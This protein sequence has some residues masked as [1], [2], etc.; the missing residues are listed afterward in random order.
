MLGAKSGYQTKV[1]LKSP[2]VRGVHCMIHR[3]AIACKTLPSFLK[4]VLNSVIKI[5]NYIKSVVTSRLVRQLCKEMNADHK[6]LLYYTA[7][8]WLSEN[9]VIGR[10]FELRSEMKQV[11]E[12]EKTT[13]LKFFSDKSWLWGLA[14]LV[15]IF[16]QLNKI[17]LRLQGPNTNILQFKDVLCGLVEKIQNWNQKVNQGNFAIFENLSRFEPSG[18]SAQ[19][20]LDISEHLQL[21]KREF[22]KYFPDLA[23]RG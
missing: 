4:D 15:D 18:I 13:F 22:R 8:C 2:Q 21:L 3:Y 16:K 12:I 20:Q 17:N 6:T 23:E 1:K 7:V 10:F 5:V 19:T 9:N 14:Y 11:L